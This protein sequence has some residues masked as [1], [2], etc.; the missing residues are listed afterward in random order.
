M[1]ISAKGL[2]IFSQ[3]CV[4]LATAK[5]IITS[6]QVAAQANTVTIHHCRLQLRPILLLYIT[7]GCSSGQYC[8]YTSL[9]VA[10]QANTVITMLPANSH[11]RECYDGS[12]GVLRYCCISD[13]TR[14]S[15]LSHSIDQYKTRAYSLTAVQ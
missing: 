6:L 13:N 15:D 11:V 10:A 5:L 14:L 3:C 9:Q 2:C 7:A 4:Q 1:L 8:Y 12:E